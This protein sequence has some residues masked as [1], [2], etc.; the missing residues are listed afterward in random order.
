MRVSPFPLEVPSVIPVRPRSA[1]VRC[2]IAVA[3]SMVL[4]KLVV[5]V[6]GLLAVNLPV[7]GLAQT[8]SLASSSSSTPD[9]V[10]VSGQVINSITGTPI[11]RVL[12][13]LN[14]RVMLTDHEGKFR[15]EQVT[16]LQFGQATSTFVNL[17]VTKPGYYQ[18]SDPYDAMN[19]SVQVDQ[20]NTPLV[21][22]LYPEALITGTIVGPDGEPLAHV[23]VQARR[24]MFDE[25]GHRWGPGAQGQS[26]IHGDFRMTVPAG[27]YKIETRY[28][29]RNGGSS[30]AVMPVV[31]PASGGDSTAQ[32]IHLRNGEEQHFD[33]RPAV[34]RTYAVPVSEELPSGDRGFP[35]VTARTSNG[36]SFNVPV[37]QN[38]GAGHGTIS[39]PIG[40]Y[41]LSAK[42]Q[43]Q[44]GL[45]I[46]ETRLTV[47]GAASEAE[48][49]GVVLRF[50][51]VPSIPVDLSIDPAATSNT[52]S[53]SGN[54]QASNTQVSVRSGSSIQMPGAVLGAQNAPN[55]L[56]FG[57]SLQRVDQDNEDAQTNIGLQQTR[58][59]GAAVFT[60]PPGTY[61]LSARGQGVWYI[62][63]A[64]F[65]TSDLTTENL[66]VAAGGS[67]ATIH[68]VVTNQT[69]GLQ[70]TVKMNG[71]AASS[72]I[73]LISTAP[74]LTP[75]LTLHSNST[76]NFSN[77]FLAPGTYRAV[78]FERR[79]AA[80]FSDPASLD[81]Y[82]AYVQSVTVT[83][84]NQSTVNLNVV[85]Q[86]EVKP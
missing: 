11:P 71:V 45:L 38:R 19:Q 63:S 74:G 61:R 84:G 44:E 34:R 43:N 68:I 2:G 4:V 30:E 53:S 27:D 7:C 57:L 62:R 55:P 85:P 8:Q 28:V 36:A 66:V 9:P 6:F 32:A 25:T 52:S 35:T 16:G 64:S 29:A 24:S 5:L 73:Y 46:A 69:G 17:Q 75:V 79:H 56:Q 76:G 58:N 80:D 51:E 33:I 12:V 10:T 41:S 1:A 22:R 48:T 26:D 70:G 21:V 82:S 72:W 3:R 31:L 60:A 47:T 39:L 23:G 49:A 15:F 18:S 81:A 14:S 83:A 42:S 65:G 77:P 86:M 50:V 54:Y 78:A 59:G 40:S 67:S 13:R 20:V 37:A